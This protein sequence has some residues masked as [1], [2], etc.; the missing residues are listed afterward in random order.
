MSNQFDFKDGMENFKSVYM[1]IKIEI[2]ILI[3]GLHLHGGLFFSLVAS[4]VDEFT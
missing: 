3:K 2:S 1:V 4:K